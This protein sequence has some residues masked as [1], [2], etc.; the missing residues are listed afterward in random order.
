MGGLGYW[1]EYRWE[2]ERREREMGKEVR[3]RGDRLGNGGWI[4]RL[5]RKGRREE[6]KKRRKSIVY[7]ICIIR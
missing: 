2:E 6:R 5:G 3:R 7:S 1:G 4:D